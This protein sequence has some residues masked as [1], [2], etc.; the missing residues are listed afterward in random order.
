M[1][2]WNGYHL[3]LGVERRDPAAVAAE[4]RREMERLVPEFTHERRAQIRV[5]D[6]AVHWTTGREHGGGVIDALWLSDFVTDLDARAAWALGIRE[7]E[8][9]ANGGGTLYVWM[10]GGYVEVD[11][12]CG[13]FGRA[14]D[15]AVA[16]FERQWDASGEVVHSW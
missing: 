14:A 4:L 10:D 12:Y 2:S 9:E 1:G 16:H 6:D 8:A 3:T 13:L 7:Q 11:D 5:D 15:D